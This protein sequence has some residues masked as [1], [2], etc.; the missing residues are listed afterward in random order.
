MDER[1]RDAVNDDGVGI[2]SFIVNSSFSFFVFITI[3]IR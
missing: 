1:C 2:D 3:T